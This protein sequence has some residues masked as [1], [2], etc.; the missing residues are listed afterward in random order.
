MMAETRTSRSD[1]RTVDPNQYINEA[2][3]I[4]EFKSQISPRDLPPVSAD[5][6]GPWTTDELGNGHTIVID[7]NGTR[8]AHV[9]CW[10]GDDGSLLEEKIA[11]TQPQR[12]ETIATLRADLS[13]MT[14]ARDRAT[15]TLAKLLDHQLEERDWARSA[16][17]TYDAVRA[18]LN[19]LE[20]DD[21]TQ[22]RAVELLRDLALAAVERMRADGGADANGDLP[23]ETEET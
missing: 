2:A 22:S 23:G 19:R 15:A 17:I 18:I 4:D 12:V 14:A 21:I 13:S 9:Y 7:A 3:I 11:A 6:P 1:R 10:D 5:H 16:G 20:D 8:V